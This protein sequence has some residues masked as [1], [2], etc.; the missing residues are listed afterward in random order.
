MTLLDKIKTEQLV[1]RKAGI[2]SRA[3]LLTTL[4]G[5]ASRPGLDDGKRDSTDAEVTAV[6]KKFIKNIDECISKVSEDKA[7]AF[8]EEKLILEEFLPQQITGMSL[9]FTIVGIIGSLGEYD[10]S[11]IMRELKTHFAGRY[12]GK[13]AA[14]IVDSLKP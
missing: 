13:E 1:A 6:I 8:K 9:H 11:S 4:V 5:E 2:K 3:S 14:Q 7:A 10:K 12:D